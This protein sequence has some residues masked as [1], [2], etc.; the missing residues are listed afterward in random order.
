MK[1]PQYNQP[2]C[3]SLE[4]IKNRI[5][6]CIDILGVGFTPSGYGNNGK[7]RRVEK[8]IHNNKGSNVRYD[9]YILNI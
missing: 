3:V 9:K 7:K 6:Q 4:I 5:Y 1:P 2:I 8:I